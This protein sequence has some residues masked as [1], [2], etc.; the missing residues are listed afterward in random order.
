MGV[1]SKSYRIR[2]K[3]TMKLAKYFNTHGK[4]YNPLEDEPSD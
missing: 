4:F 3:A 2:R 1:G